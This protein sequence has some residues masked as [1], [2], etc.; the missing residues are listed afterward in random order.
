MRFVFTVVA[1]LSAVA[2]HAAIASAPTANDIAAADNAFGFRLLAA[3]QTTTPRANVIL[4][5]IGAA[6]DLSMVLN[7]AEDQT[8]QEILAALALSGSD[9]E[10]INAANAQLI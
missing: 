6:L 9:I 1:L 10:A 8:R 2:P 4:S 5:P 3:V 7:G